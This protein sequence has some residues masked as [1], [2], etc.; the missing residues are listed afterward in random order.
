[1][2]AAVA[3]P[4]RIDAGNAVEVLDSLKQAAV[5]AGEQPLTLDLLPLVHFDSSAL[6]LLLQLLRERSGRGATPDAARIA[7]S[8]GIILLNPPQKL[9]ELAELYGIAEML[10]GAVAGTA[11]VERPN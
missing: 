10:F 11:D 9:Q 8:N 5:A 6:S 3:V 4:A 1:M 7:G 2:E